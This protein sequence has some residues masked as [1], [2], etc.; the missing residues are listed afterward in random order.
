MLLFRGCFCFL[1]FTAAFGVLSTGGEGV[2][3]VPRVVGVSG[4]FSLTVPSEVFSTEISPFFGS[5]GPETFTEPLSASVFRRFAGGSSS[6]EEDSGED[7]ELEL[8]VVDSSDSEEDSDELDCSASELLSE[9]ESES[10]SD[11]DEA[12]GDSLELEPEPDSD[13][14]SE[15]DELEVVLDC[16]LD[17]TLAFDSNFFLGV[18]RL[19]VS[20]LEL[21]SSELEEDELDSGYG[22]SYYLHWSVTRNFR[23]CVLLFGRFRA[24]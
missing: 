2:L 18:D 16:V 6:S 24:F 8:D 11:E 10:E 1:P 12:D 17:F 14:E 5:V 20:E 15:L 9:S 23:T 19:S 22:S 3:S 4:T 7:P 13:S 21:L